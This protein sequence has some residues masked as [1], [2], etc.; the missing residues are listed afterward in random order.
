MILT[1]FNQE[2]YEKAL[3]AEGEEEGIKKGIEQ[4]LQQGIKKGVQQG[5]TLARKIFELKNKGANDMEIAE[6]LH[7]TVETVKSVIG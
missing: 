4:G 3:L 7:I 1:D 6:E 5:L 2:E